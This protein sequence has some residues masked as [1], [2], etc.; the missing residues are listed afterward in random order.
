MHTTP[1]FRGGVSSDTT[2]LRHRLC[3]GRHVLALTA[4]LQ[5][6]L[7]PPLVAACSNDDADELP[8]RPTRSATAADSTA[9]DSASLGLNIKCDTTWADTI[10][11]GFDFGEGDDNPHFNTDDPL[12]DG[13]AG[14][15]V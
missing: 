3:R 4:C 6:L 5:L 2:T 13:N 7:L 10:H 15:A 1:I 11:V 12:P 9:A 8:P 14:E